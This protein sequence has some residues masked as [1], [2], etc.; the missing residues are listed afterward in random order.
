MAAAC[1]VDDFKWRPK[2]IATAE[3]WTA[4]GV[5]IEYPFMTADAVCG[6]EEGGNV[7]ALD[8][9]A[10]SARALVDV[11]NV[12]LSFLCTLFFDGGE[13]LFDM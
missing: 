7:G 11:V 12:L 2:A 8:V 4:D 6:V 3:E 1:V 13:M 5:G 10:R 9:N